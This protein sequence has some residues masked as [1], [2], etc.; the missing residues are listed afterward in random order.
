MGDASRQIYTAQHDKSTLSSLTVTNMANDN[1][2]SPKNSKKRFLSPVG[3]QLKSLFNRERST[4]PSPSEGSQGHSSKS[5]NRNFFRSTSMSPSQ[6]VLSLS[7]TSPA[8]IPGR[9]TPLG[10]WCI[11]FMYR[12]N[13]NSVADSST[14]IAPDGVPPNRSSLIMD[15][16]QYPDHRTPP[17]LSGSRTLATPLAVQSGRPSTTTSAGQ[18]SGENTPTF[19]GYRRLTPSG[20]LQETTTNSASRKSNSQSPMPNTRSSIQENLK[21]TGR[22]LQTLIKRGADIVDSNP[23]KVVLGLVKAIIEINNAV[24]DNKDA[25]SRQIALTGGQLEEVAEALRDWKP[26]NE[27][28]HPWMNHFKVTLEEE[29]RGLEKLSD[30]SNFRKFLDH[31]DEQGRIRDIFVRI[32]EARVRFE[33]ALGVR[34]FKAV[35][36]MDEAIK[37]LFLDRLKP[38]DI[39]HH[40]Y[41]LEGE[42]GRLL[43]REVCIPGTRVRI[44]DDIVTWAKDTSLESPNVYWLFGHAG[45][46]KTTL[47]YTIA[48]RFEFAGDSSDT[49]FLGGNFFCSRQFD[50]TRLSKYI[51]RTIVYHLALKCKPFSDALIGSGRLEIITQSISTQLDGLLFGPWQESQR[52]YTS[53][54]PHYLIVIDA[55]DEIDGTGGSDFLREL[56]NVI[57]KKSAECLSGLKF[58]VTS[59][60][61]KDLVTHV[62]SL[63]RKQLYRLQDVK[64]EEAHADVATYLRVSLPH[65]VDSVIMD[66]LVDN[67]AGLFIYAA[68]VVRYV[69]GY[70]Q[71]EHAERLSTLLV[72]GSTNPQSQEETLLDKLYHQILSDARDRFKSNYYLNILH[73][74]LCCAEPT[75]T[76]LV[77]ELLRSSQKASLTPSIVDGV[78]KSLHAVLYTENNKVFSYHKS[79][80]DFIFDCAPSKEPFRCDK[81]KHH[82]LLT[83]SCFRVMEGLR[84][85][86]ANIPSS[87][88]FDCDNRALAGEVERNIPP[89]LSYSCRNWD[90]HLSAT[91]PTKL[92]PLHKMLAEFLQLRTL[93]WIEAM[94]LLHSRG[95]CYSMLQTARE[96]VIESKA[97]VDNLPLAKN[98][99]EAG[100]FALY[101]SG[102]GAWSSTPHLY[103]STL[104][105]WPRKSDLIQGWKS[106]FPKIPKFVN[107]SLGGTLLMTLSLCS[108]VNA[109]AFSA[110]GSRIISG[111]TDRLVQVWDALTGD[112][113]LVLN[114]HTD[115]VYSVAF[116]C[117]GSHIISGS[118]DGSVRVWD[119][120]TGNEKLVLNGHTNLVN[121]V[122]FSSDGSC[123]ISG[124]R[125]KSVRVWDALTGYK[126]LVLNGHTSD[127]CSVA[128][129]SDGSCIVSGSSDNSVRVWDALTGDEKLVLNGHTDLV[130]SVAFSSDGS[131]IVSGSSD[132]SVRVWDALA[133][134]EK[135][136]LN[137]HTYSVNSV[138]FSSDG[139]HIVSGSSDNSVQVW[140]AL[141]GDKKLVLNGHSYSVYSV[142]FSSD[143]SRIIS[144][145]WDKS[146]RVWDAL[147][148]DKKIVLNGH[149]NSVNSVA[150]S[151]D[152]NC[153]V[154]GS[155]DKS[156]QVWDTLTGDK[157]LVL[158]GHTNSVNSVAFSNDGSHIVSGSRD[159]SVCVWDALTGDKKLVLN[160]HTYSVNS[161]AFSSDGSYI[162]SGSSDKSVR[163]WDALTGNKK[164]VLNGHTNSVYSVAFSSDGSCIVSGSSDESVRV[165]DAL[166]G[167]KK[168]VLNS[169]T[170]DLYS[171]AFSS[172]G[173]RI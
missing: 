123:I 146:V 65:L 52:A 136:F 161:V 167:N 9:E 44:L 135:L 20:L 59:R 75:S 126:K 83:D 3:E 143:G 132:N 172:D 105:T 168:L 166:T 140:D 8:E 23:A 98:L 170:S 57:N 153:I 90:H 18:S 131:R 71:D 74:F 151:S 47:A 165:W 124:S 40:N 149:T 171:V 43:R 21:L 16:P 104:A 100:S 82:Q 11:F 63:E 58:F 134:V 137:G 26:E 35:Y 50:K 87:F 67:A 130:N 155:R 25:V 96:W 139:S 150:F 56:V 111:S 24:K 61:D 103:I 86:I 54:Q 60:S 79:F 119:V 159:K 77:A 33:L 15:S 70:A 91:E 144:G 10:K 12:L 158:N 42:E 129:S 1:S 97:S 164:L 38:S 128:F 152:G 51:I 94:N 102:S 145:S 141:T 13:C 34:V 73:T 5:K 68:T 17:A 46:G 45:S 4:S 110:D 122:A 125:D 78:L 22:A 109:V 19:H 117:D 30:E 37:G 84:F 55:L 160:G 2:Q 29:L 93:F 114:G 48:R 62:N 76:S 14:D 80:S 6:W 116:S 157:K 113:K 115:S 72:S 95:R 173:S 101:F 138:A 162:V 142:A 147:T 32:N 107:A 99:T 53:T 133:G 121:S 7:L 41:L 85:N 28:G 81:A 112:K 120:L 156:V 154:S 66:R 169:Y 27:E 106:Y 148:G 92:N 69:E 39:A 163:V 36:K 49:I 31:E 118:M 108:G 127:V 89:V 88:I 64:E